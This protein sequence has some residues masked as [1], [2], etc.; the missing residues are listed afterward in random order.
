MRIAQISASCLQRVVSL[1]STKHANVSLSHKSPHHNAFLHLQYIFI[2]KE[3]SLCTVA[4]QQ[5]KAVTETSEETK[6]VEGKLDE[7]EME[8]EQNSET[9]VTFCP[10]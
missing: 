7:E 5:A 1:L 3:L 6:V 9:R 2:D 10:P 8:E 4:L